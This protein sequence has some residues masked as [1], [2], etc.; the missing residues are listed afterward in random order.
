MTTERDCGPKTCV[1][2]RASEVF[3]RIGC[4]TKNKIIT[5]EDKLIM[6]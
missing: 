3:R 6:E 4:F 2:E 1:S 5:C